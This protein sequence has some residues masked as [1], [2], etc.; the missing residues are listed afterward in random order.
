[1]GAEAVTPP[2]ATTC[3]SHTHSPPPGFDVHSGGSSGVD[4]AGKWAVLLLLPAVAVASPAVAAGVASP[5]PVVVAPPP[6]SLAAAPSWPLSTPSPLPDGATTGGV[7]WLVLVLA[8]QLVLVELVLEL[9]L[10]LAL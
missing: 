1:M 7:L 10:V 5:V 3:D 8:A 4:A 2:R 9:A 6:L